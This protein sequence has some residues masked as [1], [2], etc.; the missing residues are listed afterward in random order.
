MARKDEI[1]M[2]GNLSSFMLQLLQIIWINIL[3]SGDNAVVIALACRSLPPKSRTIG[4]V[5]GAGVAIV[6]RIIFTLLVVSLLAIPYLR[7]GGGLLLVWI[8]VKLLTDEAN[9]SNVAEANSVWHAVRIVAIADMVMSLDNVLAI[10]AVAKESNLLVII[11]LGLSIPLIV[12]GAQLVITMLER[13]PWLVWVGAGLLGFVAGEL[14]ASEPAIKP[15]LGSMSEHTAEYVLGAIGIAIVLA[16][17]AVLRKRQNGA[18]SP[19]A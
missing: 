7:L 11:G 9:E 10:A 17:G 15:L 3:L 5:A 4:I 16:L 1:R 8:A 13:F 18:D 14:L 6:L 12:F 2:D 19:A